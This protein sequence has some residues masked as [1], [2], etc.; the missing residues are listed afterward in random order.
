MRNIT[1]LPILY[2]FCGII[3]AIIQSFV[4]IVTDATVLISE[5]LISFG[6]C[7]L[8][9]WLIYV[10]G[11]V[12]RHIMWEKE[13][14]EQ[15]PIFIFPW[16]ILFSETIKIKFAVDPILNGI[17]VPP[18]LD[19]A[20]EEDENYAAVTIIRIEKYVLYLEI[21]IIVAIGAI[22]VFIHWYCLSF[23][24]LVCIGIFFVNA[25]VD[26][27]IWHGQLTIMEKIRNGDFFL[28]YIKYKFL[29]DG[30]TKDMVKRFR[31]LIRA[32]NSEDK[33][34]YFILLIWRFTVASACINNSILDDDDIE[35]LETHLI[36]AFRVK[37][38]FFSREQIQLII[39]YMYYGIINND[40]GK[41]NIAVAELTKFAN[42][43]NS[44]SP[45][46]V[47]TFNSYIEIGR[48]RIIPEKDSFGREV[49]LIIKDYV[50]KDFSNYKTVM[51][52]I[53][54]AVRARC[55]GLD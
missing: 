6:L 10:V 54:M 19:I 42:Q 31:Q 32:I 48:N 12:S 38:P 41:T 33:Q 8:I 2:A 46:A 24:S 39:L 3:V 51:E 45:K 16:I 20:C 44:F 28:Y 36:H 5:V 35:Y 43:L 18:H 13:G 29:F 50:Y 40:I 7:A 34:D 23:G 17:V 47:E 15:M 52:S 27:N 4:A 25:R 1:Y 22:S 30:I 49:T 26:D 37:R 55:N 11:S 14:Y 9:C 21:G 53:D